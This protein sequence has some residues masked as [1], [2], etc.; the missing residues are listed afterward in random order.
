MGNREI[1]LALAAQGIAVFPCRAGGEHAKQPMPGVFWRSTSTTDR[2]QIDRWWTR[3]PEAAPGVDLAKAGF[4]V[5][6][7]DRHGG[8]DGVAA[9]E[10]LAAELGLPSG[11]PVVVT[12]SSGQHVWF[13]QPSGRPPLG[14]SRGRLPSGIDVRGAGGFVIA[15]GS[16]MTDRPSYSDADISAAFEAPAKLIEV[17]EGGR[18]EA[19][20]ETLKSAPPLAPADERPSDERVRAY[21][22][23][24]V[25]AVVDSAR[26][27]GKG[28]RNEALNVA[29]HRLG[30]FVGAGWMTES[31]VHSLLEQAAAANGLTA[32]DGVRQVRATIRSGLRAGRAK[33]AVL[34]SDGIGG[35][36]SAE[37]G[38]K[39]AASLLARGQDSPLSSDEGGG[40]SSA[41]LTPL[42]GEH[43][44]PPGLV[45]EIARWIVATARHPQPVLALGAAL[46]VVGTA[47]G[48]RVAGPTLSGTHLYVI[49]LAPSGAGKDHMIKQSQRLLRAGGMKSHIGPSEFISMPAVINFMLRS[50][51]ALCCM[52]EFGA[53]LKRVNSHKAS[54]FEGAVSKVLRT[55]WGHSFTGMT[56]PEWAGKATQDIMAPALSIFG[57]STPEEFFASLEGADADNGVLNRFLLLGSHARPDEVEPSSNPLEVPAAISD[58]LRSLYA[59][60]APLGA[61][62]RNDALNEPRPEM[63]TWGEGG[64]R[65]VYE[66]FA[67]K[68]QGRA[69]ASVAERPFLARTVEMALRIA[70]IVAAGQGGETLDADDMQAGIAIAKWSADY[71]ISGARDYLSDTETQAQAQLIV[72]IVRKHGGKLTHGG[73]LRALQHRFRAKDLKEI[74]TS[75]VEAGTLQASEK[76]TGEKGGRPTLI[77]SL[78]S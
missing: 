36:G 3:W 30:Q 45:G 42:P 38:R 51:L 56:T 37:F 73:L 18:A 77:Y 31:E 60:T 75:M 46:T 15:P 43:L 25:P 76:P 50:P 52:D 16:A 32:E 39:I 72:R 58:R 19:Q 10:R 57:A 28:G 5:V 14:N 20:P 78:A 4:L 74:L 61:A 27:A 48:R 21:L 35:D 62:Q 40:A 71:M 63:L 64:A 53:F 55:A 44:C 1:A 47:I 29:A 70:T 13:R 24:A 34:G 17:L 49:G 23:A 22:D 2:D 11:A 69:D 68:I 65:D 26:S 7:P 33:P 59:G 67:K 8:P 9:W 41:A 6:D 12:P 66:A 54:G